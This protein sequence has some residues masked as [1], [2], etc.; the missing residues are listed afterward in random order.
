MISFIN[1]QFFKKKKLPEMFLPSKNLTFQAKKK[2]KFR[3]K[4]C[5]YT[6]LTY[7]QLSLHGTFVPC[8]SHNAFT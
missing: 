2:K 6:I 1:T 7:F 5:D 3:A 8:D 4:E